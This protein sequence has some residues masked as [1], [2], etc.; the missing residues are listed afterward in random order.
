MR[1]CRQCTLLSC[2]LEFLL[3]IDGA[4]ISLLGAC[5][6]RIALSGK[7]FL[8]FNY[9]YQPL[10]IIAVLLLVQFVLYRQKV[11]F[12]NKGS[13]IIKTQIR[14]DLLNKLFEL[15]PAYTTVSRTGEIANTI[16]NKVEWLSNYYTLYLPAASSSIINAFFIVIALY[17]IDGI[18]ASICLVSCIGMLFCPILFYT[19]TKDRG[20]KEWKAYGDYYSDCLDSVQGITTLKAFN[21][22]QR[23]CT[24]IDKKGEEFRRAIMSQL[25]ITMLENGVLELFLQTGC[26][27]SVATATVRAAL[28]IISPDVLVFALFL[29][30]ACFAP[31]AKLGN[32]WHMGYRGITASYSISELLA[33]K[34]T[35]SLAKANDTMIATSNKAE[36]TGDIEFKDVSFSYDADFALKNITFTVKNRTMTALVGASG[37]GKST[38]A[39]LLAGFY[40]VRSGEIYVGEMKI[41]EQTVGAII[42]SIRYQ[43]NLQGAKR[44]VKGVIQDFAEGF[45]F[46]RASRTIRTVSLMGLLINFGI[47]PLTV[48]QTPYVS[49]YLKMG[50]ETLSYIKIL[51]SVG[52]MTGAAL[53][54]KLGKIKTPAIVVAAGVIM[55][56]ALI[57]MS[58]A[59]SLPSSVL[60]MG[61]LTLS[62]VSIGFGGGL[63]N[64][65][66]GSSVMKAVPKEMMGRISGFLAALMQASMPVASFICSA[67]AVYFHIP[68]IL[69]FFGSLTL[70]CYLALY[71]KKKLDALC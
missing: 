15:G 49:D 43:E 5:A 42:W 21:A 63:L 58:I 39:H 62:M 55:G 44:T 27:L 3:T 16:S 37:S 33:K 30:A 47:M 64:V 6:I 32:A 36:F 54:P 61:I 38:I 12:A 22:N 45:R 68:H 13:R 52:M 35:L 65:V 17:T 50:P 29:T 24:Y 2:F 57:E 56:A 59:Q 14:Q 69:V 31:M 48:F 18:T 28:G 4:I 67:L 40:P 23:R 71:F 60:K 46:I 53:L 19:F 25:R 51:M 66:I 70:L 9:I 11:S 41:S 1:G 26:A 8:G 20:I 34:A 7:P 10:M